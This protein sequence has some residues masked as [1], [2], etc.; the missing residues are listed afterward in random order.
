[1][2]SFTGVESRLSICA[3]LLLHRPSRIS[4]E[5]ELA[6]STGV[7]NGLVDQVAE[8]DFGVRLEVRL[9]PVFPMVSIVN[10]TASQHVRYCLASTFLGLYFA[11]LISANV[12]I[13][14]DLRFV[15]DDLQALLDSS[16][17]I[18]VVDGASIHEEADSIPVE[19][20]EYGWDRR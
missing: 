7:T 6:E 20:W 2:G 11:V 15:V 3:A 1:M 13:D 16:R 14:R 4:I 18:D 9:D 10:R 17:D 19:R 8:V 12:D 5:R